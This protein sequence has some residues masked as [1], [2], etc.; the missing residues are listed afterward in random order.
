MRVRRPA[1]LRG[2]ARAAYFGLVAVVLHVVF[3]AL[4]MLLS[5]LLP[6]P[7]IEPEVERD[8]I[9]KIRAFRAKRDDARAQA[10]LAKV[11]HALEH[12]DVNVMPPILAAV[13]SLATLGEICGTLEGVFGRYR[14]PEGLS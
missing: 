13:E 14:P 11:R 6:S 3:A 1:R 10:A 2:P 9:A 8:Q 5:R 4:G 12:D 7:K